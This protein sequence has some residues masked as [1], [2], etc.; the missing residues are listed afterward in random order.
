M[1]CILN[2][3]MQLI[4]DIPEDLH[5]RLKIKAI[6]EKTT[7]KDLVTPVLEKLVK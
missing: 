3:D 7:L 5:S 4:I 2:Y 1:Q 6:Q